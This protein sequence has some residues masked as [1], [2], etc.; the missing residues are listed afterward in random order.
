[1][2]SCAVGQSCAELRILSRPRRDRGLIPD[3]C[4]F[5]ALVEVSPG[6]IAAALV[7]NVEHDLWYY[8]S[9]SLTPYALC[10]E[11]APVST[12]IIFPPL[13]WAHLTSLLRSRPSG[14][15]HSQSLQVSC[16]I[17]GISSWKSFIPGHLTSLAASEAWTV[18]LL[19][20]EPIHSHA[21]HMAAYSVFPAAVSCSSLPLMVTEI[22]TA[23]QVVQLAQLQHFRRFISM[24]TIPRHPCESHCVLATEKG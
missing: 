18:C 10:S 23:P 1:M 12:S 13:F 4:A 2:C 8:P 6:V 3:F 9:L 15:L 5:P 11:I 14:C 24:H 19:S 17:V 21:G 7:I 22:P 20:S 16:R